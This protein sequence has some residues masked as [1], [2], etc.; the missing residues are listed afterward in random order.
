MKLA[1]ENQ[2]SD[3]DVLAQQVERMLADEKSDR[4]VRDFLGQWLLLSKVNA[5]TPDDGLYPEFDELLANAIPKEPELFFKELVSENL[6]L[7]NIIDSDFAFVNRRLAKHYGIDEIKGQQ[8]RKVK[9]PGDSV[10]GGVLTQAAIFENDGQRYDHLAGGSWQL[11]TDQFFGHAPI[12]T[13][14]R[15]RFHRARHTRQD[16]DSRNPCGPPR[17]RELQ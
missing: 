15:N 12:A 8:F 11:C 6:S 17:D 10:R 3:S 2:L 13:S 1:S 4:F 14:A 9:L 5:T 16:D 7:T